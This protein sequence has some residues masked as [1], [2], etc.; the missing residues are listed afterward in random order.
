MDMNNDRMF[1]GALVK[2][3][4]KPVM[5]TKISLMATKTWLKAGHEIDQ[6]ESKSYNRYLRSGL[7]PDAEARNRIASR[8]I[9]TTRNCLVNVVLDN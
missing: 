6:N 5:L 2:A 9:I 8:H 4:C 1:L 7:N 3:Y